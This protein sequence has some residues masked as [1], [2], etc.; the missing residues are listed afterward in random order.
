MSRHEEM[1]LN[2]LIIY[3]I[4]SGGQKNKSGIELVVVTMLCVTI[5]LLKM[6]AG[7][8][9]NFTS[10]GKMKANSKF[11]KWNL[12]SWHVIIYSRSILAE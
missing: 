2:F 6:E 10:K 7:T 11:V 3:K 8:T 5:C 4:M 1:K 12:I 9:Y